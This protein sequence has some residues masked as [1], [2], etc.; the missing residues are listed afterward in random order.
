MNPDPYLTPLN[1]QSGTFTIPP[2]TIE[3][4]STPL[5]PFHAGNGEWY[6]SDSCRSLSSFGYTYPEIDDWDQTPDQ[7]QANVTAAVNTLYN[8]FGLFTKRA[9]VP[10]Q[11]T[12]DWSVDIC[13]SKFDLQ[14]D[15]FI[16][17]LFL[18]DVPEDPEDW[19]TSTKCVGS[20]RV[21]PPPHSGEGLFPEV[22][23]YSEVSLS[24]G[25]SDKGID[26]DDVESTIEYL[27]GNF[28]WIV[29]KV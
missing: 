16:I 22:L 23:T 9:L 14:G 21:S 15:R 25:L 11:Q 5:E 29:Q 4:S 8:P 26:G 28:T 17:R 13:V 19:I 24:K 18:G 7:L 10:G 20:F 6:T 2:N 3:D 1:E 12:V 27:K